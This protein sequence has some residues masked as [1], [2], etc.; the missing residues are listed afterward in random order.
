MPRYFFDMHN[1]IETR[2]EEGLELPDIAAAREQATENA[3]EMVCDSIQRHGGV[4]LEHRIDVR[5]EAGE[6]V[7]TTTF[8]QAF[9]I[10]G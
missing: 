3:R 1:D 2:D 5:D 8:R 4:N 9:T 6:I 7:V 10:T